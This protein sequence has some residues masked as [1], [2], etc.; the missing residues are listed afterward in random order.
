M[1]ESLALLRIK[2]GSPLSIALIPSKSPFW[3]ISSIC[4]VLFLVFE[5]LQALKVEKITRVIQ[6]VF[7]ELGQL[8]ELKNGNLFMAI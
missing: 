2:L 6:M 3:A 5:G 7:D 8:A 4:S 1:S